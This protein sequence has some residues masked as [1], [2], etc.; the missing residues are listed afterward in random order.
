MFYSLYTSS[1]LNLTLIGDEKGLQN[2]YFEHEL[3]FPKDLIKNDIFF[4]DI[5]LQLN[6]YFYG[7]RKTFNITLNLKGTEFQKKVWNEL[8]KIPYGKAVS[9]KYIATKIGNDKASRAIGMANNKN[10]IPII[11]PC[12]RVIGA[13]K[14]LVGYGG[15]LDIKI[16]LLELEGYKIEN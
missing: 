4:K 11:I 3:N 6:E 15:G 12:H 8:C 2:I 13:N 16:K 14:K 9:Y 5:R 10:P 7:T 1:F